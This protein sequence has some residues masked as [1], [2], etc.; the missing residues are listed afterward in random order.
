MW[1]HDDFECVEC[2]HVFEEMTKGSISLEC[3]ECKGTANR[4]IASPRI[5]WRRMGL[6]AGFPS[7]Y[8]RW[9]DA[10]TAHHK[11]GKDSLHKGKGNNLLMY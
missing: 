3:P 8:K 6:D 1:R 7:A 2:K 5:D 10:Q 11:F 4:L 9:G